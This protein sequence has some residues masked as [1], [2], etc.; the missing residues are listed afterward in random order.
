MGRNFRIA[1]IIGGVVLIVS[2]SL[3]FLLVAGKESSRK[4]TISGNQ[5]YG[6]NI[7]S[8]SDIE[9]SV[10][11]Q[12]PQKT[13]ST[14]TNDEKKDVQK[15]LIEQTV[16]L[17]EAKNKNLMPIDERI[18]AP[19]KNQQEYNKAYERAKELILNDVQQMTVEGV[20]IWFNVGNPEPPVPLSQA[21]EITRQ[22]ME[23]IRADIVAGRITMEEAGERIRKDESLSQ[24]DSIYKS[25]A[26]AKYPS[27]DATTSID[28]NLS[29]ADNVRLWQLSPSE[30]SP[31][32]LGLYRP[33]IDED[34]EEGF[35]GIYH[36]LDKSGTI[37]SYD[38]WL[39]EKIQEYETN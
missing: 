5:Q 26:Y 6:R 39:N 14:L 31:L 19:N 18:F 9:Y 4:S 29:E 15:F 27:R 28:S 16:V 2:I 20:F 33:S 17:E 13:Y 3:L 35:W 25:N 32:M 21:K 22:K 10:Q 38:D 34:P 23:A 30:F 36:V 8:P 7:F 24:F 11:N 37:T 1:A 12:Y